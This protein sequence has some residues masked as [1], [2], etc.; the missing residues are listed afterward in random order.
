M[1]PAGRSR[2]RSSCSAPG[3]APVG[4]DIAV[5]NTPT[6]SRTGIT[7]LGPRLW[8]TL[9]VLDVLLVVGMRTIWYEQDFGF[10]IWLAW[11]ALTL[12]LVVRAGFEVLARRRA[13]RTA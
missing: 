1:R 4:E 3:S 5:E 7:S 2:Q 10:A 9:V 11:V 12:F 13:R 8:G 6:R